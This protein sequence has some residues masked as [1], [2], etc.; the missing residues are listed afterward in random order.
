VVLAIM[1]FFDWKVDQARSPMFWEKGGV[2][3]RASP[4]TA[5]RPS[6]GKPLQIAARCDLSA[7][8]AG[9]LMRDDQVVRP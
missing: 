4:K 7:P 6:V 9:H 5:R 1:I 8:D 2:D 3:Q